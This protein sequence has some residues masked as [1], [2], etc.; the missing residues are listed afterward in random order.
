MYT[1][2]G[3]RTGTIYREAATCGAAWVTAELLNAEG[4]NVVVVN[5][6]GEELDSTG[7]PV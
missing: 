5:A 4:G 3:E 2:K 1:V 6:E 7:R